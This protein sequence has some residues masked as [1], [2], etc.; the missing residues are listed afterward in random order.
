M[1]SGA[2]RVVFV[3]FNQQIILNSHIM[4]SMPSM[5]ISSDSQCFHYSKS[6]RPMTLKRKLETEQTQVFFAHNLKVGSYLKAMMIENSAS[7]GI[8]T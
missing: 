5:N 8:L 1:R 7:S 4:S 6:A 2:S 3:H